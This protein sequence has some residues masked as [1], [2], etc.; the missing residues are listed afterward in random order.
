M[1]RRYGNGQRDGS[2]TAR[3]GLRRGD[4][5]KRVEEGTPLRRWTA[6]RLL[7]GEGQRGS[8]GWTA[9]QQIGRLEGGQ[10]PCL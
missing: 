6:Q 7:N 4:V 3:D 8:T 1:A 5:E 10:A 2:S 9:R